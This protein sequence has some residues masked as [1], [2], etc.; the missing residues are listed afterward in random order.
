MFELSRKKIRNYGSIPYNE[1]RP[2]ILQILISYKKLNKEEEGY[3]TDD[4]FRLS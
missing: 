1:C 3:K 4:Y 2:L